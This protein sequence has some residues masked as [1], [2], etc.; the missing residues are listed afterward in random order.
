MG[1][2]AIT[3]T[4]PWGGGSWRGPPAAGY[5]VTS[6]AGCKSRHRSLTFMTLRSGYWEGTGTAVKPD[7]DL[8]PPHPAEHLP[9]R[10]RAAGAGGQR[11]HRAVT[12]AGTCPTP[13]WPPF[14]PPSSPWS[15]APPASSRLAIWTTTSTSPWRSGPAALALRSVSTE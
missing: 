15:T 11:V 9:S 14:V 3:H 2:R 8:G 10:G 7:G 4:D 6:T 13:S 5:F 12:S 1:A